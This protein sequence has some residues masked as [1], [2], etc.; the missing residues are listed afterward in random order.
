MLHIAVLSSSKDSSSSRKMGRYIA[1]NQ[2]IA[3]LKNHSSNF[4]HH[5]DFS[6]DISRYFKELSVQPDL[7]FVPDPCV[8]KFHFLREKLSLPEIPIVGL[9]HSLSTPGILSYF[10]EVH[11]QKLHLSNHLVCTSNCAIHAI[12]QQLSFYHNCFQDA[13]RNFLTKSSVIPLGINIDA[14]EPAFSKYDARK[15]LNIPSNAFVLLWTGRFEQHCKSN[16]IPYFQV[17]KRI[18]E[19]YPEVELHFVMYGTSVME[20]LPNALHQAASTISPQTTLHILD[21]HDANLQNIALASSDVFI[22]LPDSFQETFGLTPCEA[23]ASGLPVIGTDWNGYKDTIIHSKTGFTIPTLL[24]SEFFIDNYDFLRRAHNLNFLDEVSFIAAHQVS[25]DHRLLFDAIE[26]FILSPTL[27]KIMGYHAKLHAVSTFS[28]DCIVEQYDQLFSKLVN[29]TPPSHSSF[30][31]F[32][33]TLSSKQYPYPSYNWLF[34]SWPTSTTIAS[35][36]YSLASHYKPHKL[37]MLLELDILKIY[38]N[39][40]PDFRILS[41]VYS[42]FKA[43]GEWTFQSVFDNVY[44][45]PLDNSSLTITPQLVSRCLAFLLKFNFIEVDK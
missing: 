29:A 22:S 36:K 10:R 34:S 43:S 13:S 9:T 15:I 18:N 33:S 40:L 37:S 35:V 11:F 14:F 38:S 20:A 39:L 12:K 21:G 30:S 26:K 31:C 5:L 27:S 16:H 23:M 24:S 2:I 45:F 25:F 41:M 32:S 7:C 1:N 8:A 42:L 28:W 4:I 19:H 44:S 6:S 3:A 17:F